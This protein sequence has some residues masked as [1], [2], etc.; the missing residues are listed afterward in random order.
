[1]RLHIY[2]FTLKFISFSKGRFMF[3]HLSKQ[4]IITYTFLIIQTQLTLFF[5]LFGPTFANTSSSGRMSQ[6]NG[7]EK[8]Q[9][10]V[11]FFDLNLYDF[12]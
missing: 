2:D 1:M 7:I 11:S 9:D 5:I 12:F 3:L 8:G 4:L 10:V 6:G